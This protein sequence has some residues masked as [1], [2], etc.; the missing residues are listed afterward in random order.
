MQHSQSKPDVKNEEREPLFRPTGR[1]QGLPGRAYYDPTFYEAERHTVFAKGWMGIGFAKDI[2]D[3]GDIQPITV[4]GWELIT[5]RQKDGSIKVFHNI[6][7]HRGM[8]L[9]KEKGNA[10]SIR[11]IFHCWTYALDG[12]LMATPVI[13]GVNE[14]NAEDFD[15]SE[16]GLKEVRSGQYLDIIFVNIDGQAVPLEEHLRPVRDR[17]EGAFDMSLLRDG[18]TIN[19]MSYPVNWKIAYEGGIEDYHVGFVHKKMRHSPVYQFE[20]GGTTYAGFSNSFKLE[21]IKGAIFESTNDGKTLPIF[22]KM[23]ET[24]VTDA[25][26]LFIF[27]TVIIGCKPNSVTMSVSL[28]QGPEKTEYVGRTYFIGEAATD[29]SFQKLRDGVREFWAEAF[30]E[31]DVVW[32]EVQAMVKIREDLNLETRFS[33]HWERAL[34]AFQKYVAKEVG[35]DVGRDPARA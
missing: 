23:V 12:K 31:D 8:R 18:E 1:A 26:T 24:G 9:V 33:P 30:H 17:L 32:R 19:T 35:D 5:V 2:P 13:N 3:A 15:Y 4:A 10:R 7:R 34:H 25:I 11:C 20:D 28:P 16:L 21:E 14:H 6:C 29:P 27:P 22:P